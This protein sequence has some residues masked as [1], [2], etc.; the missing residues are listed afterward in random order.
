MTVTTGL[1]PLLGLAV[2]ACLTGFAAGVLAMWRPAEPEIRPADVDRAGSQF[3]RGLSV[4]GRLGDVPWPDETF[5]EISAGWDRL[6]RNVT[7]QTVELP[8]IIP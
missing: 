4:A 1:W 2:L 5:S 6:E 7:G 3:A 8:R